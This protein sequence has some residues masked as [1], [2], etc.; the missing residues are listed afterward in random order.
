VG[1]PPGVD[2]HP[3]IKPTRRQRRKN[4]PD[5]HFLNVLTFWGVIIK[6]ERRRNVRRLS[7]NFFF[8]GFGGNRREFLQGK[9][10][11][12]TRLCLRT[13][14]LAVASK[15][16]WKITLGSRPHPLFSPTVTTTCNT[17]KLSPDTSH[18]YQRA[19]STNLVRVRTLYSRPFG[20]TKGLQVTA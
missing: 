4:E 20:I 5:L 7:R 19:S 15:R 18:S 8:F 12:I 10:E 16:D 14:V 13:D 2:V 9:S 3:S 11:T 6:C 1:R 17:P